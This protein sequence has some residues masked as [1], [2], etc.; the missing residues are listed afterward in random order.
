MTKVELMTPEQFR[1]YWPLIGTQ[2]DLV[3]H[4]W[5]L[6]WTKDAL[7]EG[8]C[9]EY[10]QCWA[11]SHSEVIDGVIFSQVSFYP[12]NTVFRAFLA[13]GE[14]IVDAVDDIEAAFERYCAIRGVGVAEISGRPGWE[15]VLR[16]KGFGRTGTI[17]TKRLDRARLQ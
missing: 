1:H 3:P 4:L 14:G 17:M 15:S 8:V 7:Y 13:F 6:L 11:V 12:A 5:Q 16:K 9:S 10:L 2:L